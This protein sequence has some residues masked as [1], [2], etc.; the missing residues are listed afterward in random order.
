[1]CN[2]TVQVSIDLPALQGIALRR[3]QQLS[4]VLRFSRAAAANISEEE[5]AQHQ[6]FFMLKPSANTQ[7][8]FAEAKVETEAWIALH[9]LRD[10]IDV[11]NVFLEDARRCCALYKLVKSPAARQSDLH[12]LEREGRQFHALGLPVK[13]R[14]LSEMFGVQSDFDQHILSLNAARNCLVHR[15]GIVTEADVDQNNELRI[16]W[17][18]LRVEAT[19]P[20]ERLVRVIDEPTQVDEGWSL[21][22]VIG[23]MEK[24]YCTGERLRLSYRELLGALFSH[25]NYVNNLTL[26]VQKYAESLGFTFL[27]PE[28]EA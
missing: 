3:L 26:S 25:Q 18:D 21:K 1:V 4:D 19:S 6:E 12:Q 10:A 28:A 23:P 24:R 27:P 16:Q 14:Q 13:I 20:D 17:T 8:D 11:V 9:C 7:R 5:F 22:L 15:L 2:L